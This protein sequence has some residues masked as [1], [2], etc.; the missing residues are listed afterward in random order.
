MTELRRPQNFLCSIEYLI[1]TV[2][3][4]RRAGS[5]TS[6]R[7]AINIY[8]PHGILVARFTDQQVDDP[9]VEFTIVRSEEQFYPYFLHL[10]DDDSA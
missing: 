10:M 9:V 1:H 2:G 7:W 3:R 8:P 5:L 4:D 6:G